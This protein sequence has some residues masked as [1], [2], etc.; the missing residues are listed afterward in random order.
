MA[1]LIA[2]YWINPGSL[3]VNV[4]R[5]A[6]TFMGLTAAMQGTISTGLNGFAFGRL[7]ISS[8]NIEDGALWWQIN[9]CQMT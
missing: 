8:C 1:S 7:L 2:G 4:V 3:D 9:I 6:V 5:N